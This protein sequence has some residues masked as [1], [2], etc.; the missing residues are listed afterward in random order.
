MVPLHKQ[1]DD[2]SAPVI[3][4]R[5]DKVFYGKKLLVIQSKVV[6]L[7]NIINNNYETNV[8]C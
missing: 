2:N 8:T 4:T 5:E 7:Y 6:K 3:D 1:V